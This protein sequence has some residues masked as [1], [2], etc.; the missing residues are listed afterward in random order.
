MVGGDTRIVC[1]EEY[2]HEIVLPDR[3]ARNPHKSSIYYRHTLNRP[4]PLQHAPFDPVNPG[5][6]RIDRRSNSR[7]AVIFAAICRGD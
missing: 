6:R 1:S 3:T 4:T 5:C 7:I 2:D